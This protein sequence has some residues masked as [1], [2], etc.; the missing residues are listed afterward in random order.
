MF[1]NHPPSFPEFMSEQKTIYRPLRTS[2]SGGDTDS[3][4]YEEQNYC[5]TYYFH[6]SGGAMLF[7]VL[8]TQPHKD[9]HDDQ[10]FGETE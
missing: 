3:I 8:P 10:D 2:F 9:E 4:V 6:L 7:G 5:C 1:D